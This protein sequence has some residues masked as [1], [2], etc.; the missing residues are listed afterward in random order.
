MLHGMNGIALNKEPRPLPASGVSIDGPPIDLQGK[1]AIVLAIEYKPDSGA[2]DPSI[3]LDVQWSIDGLTWV[4]TTVGDA[5]MVAS[6]SDVI[7]IMQHRLFRYTPTQVINA[8]LHCL[9]FRGVPFG[10]CRV[11]ARESGDTS[12]PG[13]VKV[14]FRLSDVPPSDRTLSPMMYMQET[15]MTANLPVVDTTSIVEDPLDG[16]KEV[17]FD[18]GA[19][20]TATVRVVFIPDQNV[21]LD[22]GVT[23]TDAAATVA[24]NRGGTARTTAPKL[25]L[26][27]SAAGGMGTQTSGGGDTNKLPEQDET[28]TNKVN[29]HYLAMATGESVFWNIPM[30]LNWDAGSMT[31]TFLWLPPGGSDDIKLEIKG[32]SFANGDALD[33]ALGIAV[34]VEDTV[35]TVGDVQLSSTT[36]SF[37]LAGAPAAGEYVVIEVKRVAP[38]GT[39]LGV[40]LRLL[41][42][43]LAYTA[44]GYSES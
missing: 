37:T 6:G 3:E 22:P 28:A 26:L 12:N 7:D 16:T 11:V 9:D 23:F 27:L 43:R 15:V 38:A 32:G 31:A 17:R 4:P 29:Y 1:T 35:L 10:W 40:D 36:S 30:P 21:D 41:G 33:T 19:V 24:V 34:A 42:V 14:G 25:P 2:T 13:E 20:A 8:E 44:A 18:V 39:D 5:K